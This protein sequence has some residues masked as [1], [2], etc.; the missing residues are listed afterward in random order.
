MHFMYLVFKIFTEK[1]YQRQRKNENEVV[2]KAEPRKIQKDKIR[3]Q[4]KNS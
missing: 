1:S 2:K 4:Y 3:K